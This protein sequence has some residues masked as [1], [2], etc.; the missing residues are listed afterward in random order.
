M[1]GGDYQVV[2]IWSPVDHRQ[3]VINHRAHADPLFD[4][5]LAHRLF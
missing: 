1:T 4:S 2:L 5:R 3:I